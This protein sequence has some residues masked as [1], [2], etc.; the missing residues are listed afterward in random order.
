MNI[1]T[2]VLTVSIAEVVVCWALVRV[3]VEVLCVR[4]GGLWLWCSALW[5]LMCSLAS[6]ISGSAH[7]RWVNFRSWH[8]QHMHPDRAEVR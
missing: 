3:G 8:Q 2:Q 7:K 6:T 1:F 5:Q 4:V